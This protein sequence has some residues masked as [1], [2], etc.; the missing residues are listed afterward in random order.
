[1][2]RCLV[3]PRV[4]H[5]QRCLEDIA[6]QTG[7]REGRATAWRGLGVAIF[8]A[9]HYDAARGF[10][11]FCGEVVSTRQARAALGRHEV[12]T[13]VEQG[14]E[15]EAVIRQRLADLSGQQAEDVFLFPSGMAANYAVHRMLQ[16]LWG[17]RRTA[18]VDFPYVDVLK[19]QQR[20][21]AGTH[22]LPLQ[23]DGAELAQLAALMQQEELG[24]ICVEAPSNPLLRCANLPEIDPISPST[25]PPCPRHPAPRPQAVT[26]PP[27]PGS[28]ATG[29][30]PP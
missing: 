13:T 15:A 18:Q 28:M 29:Q 6:R 7:R 12:E 21:G 10:W 11:R 8:P 26:G 2:E 1:M 3:F 5:A 4:S 14:R 23:K 24:A 30:S 19:L 20:S 27:D 16:A 17:A 22:F 9:E 25:P